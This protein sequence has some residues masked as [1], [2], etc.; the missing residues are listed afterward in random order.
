MPEIEVSQNR[1]GYYITSRN[2]S[3]LNLY[4]LVRLVEYFASKNWQSFCCYRPYLTMTPESARNRLARILDREVG[5]PDMSF[6]QGRRAVVFEVGD[7]QIVY[8]ND[9][10]FY[11]LAS[12]R[13]DLEPADPA[14]VKVGN[15]Y[16]F[17]S[18]DFLHVYE[19]GVEVR[20]VPKPKS[21]TPDGF[22][23][24][25][26]VHSKG[27]HLGCGEGTPLAYSYEKNQFNELVGSFAFRVANCTDER[28]RGEVHPR[29]LRV[30]QE[31]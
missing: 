8:E 31:P 5:Q 9:R 2:S 1:R 18:K 12:R 10:V 21:W 17:G 22:P 24:R 19:N 20:R 16:L 3:N 25:A 30:L 15:R 27:V 4:D 11:S 29:A 28:G 23:C 13:L 26:R 6:F 14:P 7:L